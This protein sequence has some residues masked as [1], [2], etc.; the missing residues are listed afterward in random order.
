[1]SQAHRGN[2]DQKKETAL[3]VIFMFAVVMTILCVMIWFLLSSRIVYHSVPLLRILGMP[4]MF[5][6]A[7]VWASIEQASVYYREHSG[8]ISFGY[9][10]RFAN[11]CMRPLSVVAIAGTLVATLR[12]LFGPGT[13]ASAIRRQLSPDALAAELSKVYPAIVPV[14]H[15]GPALIA[16][17]LPLWRRQTF[18]EDIWQSTKV[19]NKRMVVGSE[20]QMDV[21]HA[22]FRG[23]EFLDGPHFTR[24]GRRWSSMLGFQIVDIMA[25]A[26]HHESICFP[27]RMSPHG[28]VLFAVFCAY[29]YGGREGKEDA[30]KALNQVSNTCAGEKNGLP[31]LK[32]AQWVYDKYRMHPGAR[33]LL[34]VHHWEHTF[35]FALFKEAKQKGKFTHTRFIWLKPLDRIMFYVLNT[36]GRATPHAESAAAFAQYDYELKVARAGRLP[37]RMRSDGQVEANIVVKTA[38]EGMHAAYERYRTGTGDE[39]DW[40][41]HLKTW[42]GARTMEEKMKAVREEMRTM[43]GL[44]TEQV[45]AFKT[46]AVN[47]VPPENEVF[48][49]VMS[50]QWDEKSKVDEAR[51][52]SELAGGSVGA[53]AAGKAGAGGLDM[54]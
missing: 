25:D 47:E 15:L 35:L 23:G 24:G 1:M 18:P 11:D 16:D 29:A 30:K 34:Q 3:E 20:L 32:V 22:Y 2:N 49:K 6:D 54:F 38:V 41:N 14:M 53:A 9:W 5:V 13:G 50:K 46:A 43:S 8:Q 28:K 37:L 27:D 33:K 26:K 36:V 10:A 17:K 42:A 44:R 21:V 19:G 52:M 45:G 40:L 31:N 7:K 4:W 39:D 12:R 51:A 48:D